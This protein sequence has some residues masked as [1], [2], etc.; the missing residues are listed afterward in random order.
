MKL[1][2]IPNPS[3]ASHLGAQDAV[4]WRGTCLNR[5]LINFI[6]P[7]NAHSRYLHVLLE[8]GA[9]SRAVLPLPMGLTI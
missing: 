9:K 6:K 3:T 5:R 2:S 1:N 4:S 8:K 7:C